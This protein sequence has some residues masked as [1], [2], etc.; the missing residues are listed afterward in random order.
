MLTGPWAGLVVAWDEHDEFDEDIYRRDVER[1]CKAGVPGVY[2][3]GTS[4]EFYAQSFEEFERIA[5][6][7]VEVCHAHHTPAMIGCTATSTREAVRKAEVAAKLKADAI[8]VALPFWMEVPDDQVVPFFQ[9]VAEAAPGVP[10]SVYE[11]L[12]AKKALALAQ[13]EALHARIP[14]YTMVKANGG[15]LGATASGCRALSAFVNVFVNETQW[16]ELG[17]VGANG[18]CSAMV[19]WN[20]QVVLQLWKLVQDQQWDLLS[21]AL[22]PVIALHAYLDDEFEPKGFTDTAYDRM[23]GL[24]SGF[25][26]TSRQCRGPYCSPTASDIERLRQWYLDHFSDMLYKGDVS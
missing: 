2:T 4:G 5:R 3:G 21:H 7:T 11:T 6:A 16:A 26:E 13:H 18:S 12:R 22:Q 19:Y 1:C 10:L 24:A 23:G 14:T 20:P 17:P 8:Q 15:T 9:A 25:L